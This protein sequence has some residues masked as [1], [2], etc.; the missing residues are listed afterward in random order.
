MQAD[1]GRAWYFPLDRFYRGISLDLAAVYERR[2]DEPK[3]QATDFF[4]LQFGIGLTALT[5][6]VT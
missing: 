6:G 5:K 2:P 1:T 3:S 4:I